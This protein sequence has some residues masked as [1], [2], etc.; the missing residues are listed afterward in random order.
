MSPVRS[1]DGSRQRSEW[2]SHLIIW[3]FLLIE[4]FPLYMMFQVS[5][6]DNASFIANPW[7]PTSPATWNWGNWDF[8]LRLI[9]PYIAN[10]VFVATTGTIGTIGFAI[11]GAYFFARGKLPFSDALWAAFLLLMLL[12]GVTNIVPLFTQLKDLN[13]LNTLWAL[14]IVGIASAQV[15]NIFVLRHFIEDLPKD[16]FEAAEMDGAGHLQRIWHIV[17]PLSAPIIGTLFI[18]AFLAKWN[19]ILLPLIV[20]RDKELF[21]LGVGLFYLDGEY[22]K[23]WGQVMAAYSISAIPLIIVFLFAMR[24]FVKGLSAGA[25]KG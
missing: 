22:T 9:G 21:T 11:C 2:P 3:G 16:L 13:L 12:P 10:T 24:P 20:L 25:I 18:L 17:I 15:F 7:L 5:F 1:I 23:Q 6:K 4:L 8:G 14:V 19:E